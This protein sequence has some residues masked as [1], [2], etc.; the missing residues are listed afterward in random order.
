[1]T[2]LKKEMYLQDRTGERDEYFSVMII[3]N[4]IIYKLLILHLKAHFFMFFKVC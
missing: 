1:M 4:V 2:H 3:I